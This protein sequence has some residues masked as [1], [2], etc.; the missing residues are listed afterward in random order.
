LVLVDQAFLML[1]EEQGIPRHSARLHLLVAG[2]E[3][4]HLVALEPMVG[5]AV[6]ALLADQQEVEIPHR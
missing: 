3:A 5:Q 2:V 1:K 4:V 6:V